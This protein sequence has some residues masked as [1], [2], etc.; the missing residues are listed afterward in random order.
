MKRPIKFRGVD[1]DTG[2]YRY[3]ELGEISA[4]INPEYL[5]F[6]TDDAYIV[7]ADSIAQL[8]GYDRD[9]KEIYEGDYVIFKRGIERPARLTDNLLPDVKLKEPDDD[10]E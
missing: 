5:T 4:E 10:D 8:V 9:G 1:I 3:A 6:I 7:D 2:E